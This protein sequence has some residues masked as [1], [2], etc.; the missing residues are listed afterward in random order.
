M[1]VVDTVE[2]ACIL[3]VPHIQNGQVEQ[4]ICIKFCIE[5][6]HS[7][8]KTVQMIQKAAAM[9]NWWLAA[10]SRQHTRSCITSPA[11]FFVKTS[12]HPGDSALLQLRFGVLQLLAFPKTKIT[13]EREEISDCWWDSGKYNR[14]ADGD[15]E[16]CVRCLLWRGLR[17]HCPMYNVSGILYLLQQMFLLFTLRG[18]ITSGWTSN[19]LSNQYFGFLQICTKKRNCWVTRHFHFQFSEEPLHYFP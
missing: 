1:G 14:A 10:L 8:T 7:T 13:F 12:N 4:W 16:N 9:G 2:W 11:E 15:W 6:E 5:L 17:L 19:I 18:K 3:C